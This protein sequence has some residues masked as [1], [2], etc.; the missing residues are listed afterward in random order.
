MSSIPLEK[1][2]MPERDLSGGE[3]EGSVRT[4]KRA[5]RRYPLSLWLAWIVLGIA[6][7]WAIAPELFTAYSGTEGIAGSDQRSCSRPS[8]RLAHCEPYNQWP[9]CTACVHQPGVG[10]GALD[11]C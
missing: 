11:C 2:V 10:M 5:Q 3:A 1:S 4:A 7:L 6:V 9:P 8:L